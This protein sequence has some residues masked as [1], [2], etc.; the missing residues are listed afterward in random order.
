LVALLGRTRKIVI[1]EGENG[2]ALRDL[3]ALLGR[4][5]KIVILEGE[6]GAAAP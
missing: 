1:L 4:T 2:A 6:S 3:V 5:R